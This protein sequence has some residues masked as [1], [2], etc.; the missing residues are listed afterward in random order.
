MPLQHLPHPSSS[1]R[2]GVVHGF[3]QLPLDRLEPGSHEGLGLPL[4]KPLTLLGQMRF[5][6]SGD[7]FRL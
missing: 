4:S 1:L 6:P 3:V 2:D 7:I 5:E